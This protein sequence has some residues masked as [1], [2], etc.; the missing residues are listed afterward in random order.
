M[1]QTRGV[2]GHLKGSFDTHPPS[3]SCSKCTYDRQ[4]EVCSIWPLDIWHLAKARRT[5]KSKHKTCVI[6]SSGSDFSGF[7]SQGTRDPNPQTG[8]KTKDRQ[9]VLV[10]PTTSGK[11]SLRGEPLASSSS[12]G[13]SYCRTL[14]HFGRRAE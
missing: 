12:N 2:C 9:A 5:F 13:F 14:S 3:L 8:I 7:S 11:H 6:D 10:V 1:S 4:C